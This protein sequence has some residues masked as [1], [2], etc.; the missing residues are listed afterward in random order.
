MQRI[1]YR[2]LNE[3]NYHALSLGNNTTN[4]NRHYAQSWPLNIET[5]IFHVFF[6]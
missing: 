5:V 4:T 3:S 2:I 6:F 1:R